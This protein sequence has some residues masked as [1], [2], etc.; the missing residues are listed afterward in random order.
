[1]PVYPPIHTRPARRS[2]LAVGLLLSLLVAGPVAADIAE[3]RIEETAQRA[4][5]VTIYNDDLALIKDQREV[6][7]EPGE[8]RLAW[9]SVSVQ[10]RPETALLEA[11]GGEVAV[12]L[13]EQN[14]DF[15]LLTAESLLKKYVGRQVQVVRTNDAGERTVEEARVLAANDGVVLRYADRIE[16]GIV[17]HLAY[18]DVPD[19]LRDQPT[20]VLRLEAARGGSGL[21][22]L[23]YLTGGLGWQADYVAQLDDDGTSMDLN[24]WVTLTN[25]SGI[26]YRDAQVQLV[27]GEVNQV[28]APRADV[29]MERGLAMVAAAPPPEEEALYEYHLYTLPRPTDI[30]DRQ[31]KQVALLSAP[32]VPVT[33]ALVIEG[34]P[35]AYRVAGGDGW[36]PAKVE[37]RLH[38]TNRDA[39]LGIPLPKGVVRVYAR[40]SRGHAQ[41]VGEDRIDHTPKHETVSLH[42]GE[43]FDV[44]ARRKQTSFRK[45][46][47]SSAY[48]YAYEAGFALELKNA[49]PEPVAVRVLESLPGDWRILEASAPHTR[50]AAAVAAWTVEVPAEGATTLTWVAQVR[51]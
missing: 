45:L 29:R 14:F 33:R 16:T 42:L 23:S 2:G 50:E 40:D 24:G 39:P 47:G 20:L 26:A 8:N 34:R 6:A 28:R 41:F 18:P 37:A 15:D 13:L 25:R 22:E 11:R 3:R 7:L 43:S 44:T 10:I 27:A 4:L 31:T 36:A 21:F 17:G 48:D 46:S 1:M 5:A 30:L 35:S 49:K 9:R 32:R 38:F 19:D 51:Y 12:T